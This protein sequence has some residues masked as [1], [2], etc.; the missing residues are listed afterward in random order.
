MYMYEKWYV[1]SD[2]C[3]ER[4]MHPIQILEIFET[5]FGFCG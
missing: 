5:D 1:S 4:A 2:K 3:Q